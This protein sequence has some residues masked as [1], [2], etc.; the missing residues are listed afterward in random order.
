M[1]ETQQ[2]A[3][4]DQKRLGRYE[5]LGEIASGGMA[6][7]F[8]AR[9]LGHGGFQRLMAIKRLHPHLE[10]DE[11]FVRMF[12]DEAR[13]AARI[14]HPNVVATLDVEDED[15]LYIV[16]E[17]IEGVTLLQLTRA[18][19]KMGDRVP[20]PVAI[21]IALDT[22]AG[23]HAAHELRDENEAFL[24]LVHRDVSPQNILLG[25]DGSARLTDFGIAKATSRLAVTRDGQLKGKIS[26]MAPEQTRKS[27]LDRRADVFAMGVVVWELLAGRRLFSGDSDVEVLNQLLFEAVPRLRDQAPSLPSMLE[28]TV[29]R[30]LERDPNSRYPSAS[31]FA[32]A[33]ERATR[34]LGGPANHRIVAAFVNKLAGERIARE[35]GRI[36]SGLPFFDPNSTGNFKAIDT[37]ERMPTSRVRPNSNFPSPDRSQEPMTPMGR[38]FRSP[39]M[40][41]PTYSADSDPR[42]SSRPKAPHAAPLRVPTIPPV[43][44]LQDT[45][46]KA[47]LL[48]HSSA[49][50]AIIE[51]NDST[52]AQPSPPTVSS[53]EA[54]PSKLR[55]K[56]PAP[57]APQNAMSVPVSGASIDSEAVTRV[58]PSTRTPSY[59]NAV[60][61]SGMPVSML[62]GG[63]HSNQPSPLRVQ[64]PLF[65][66]EAPQPAMSSP[67]PS[68]QTSRPPDLIPPPLAFAQPQPELIATLPPPAQPSRSLAKN[69]L[70]ALGLLTA[71]AVG[72]LGA[73]YATGFFNHPNTGTPPRPYTPELADV[74]VLN[75]PSSAPDGM[76]V[77][78]EAA[79]DASVM[80]NI[81]DATL[82]D[83]STTQA[84]LADVIDTDVANSVLDATIDTTV[85]SLTTDDASTRRRRRRHEELTIS[86]PYDTPRPVPVG[87]LAKKS[88]LFS[89]D[90]NGEAISRCL[91]P[92]RRLLHEPALPCTDWQYHKP[93]SHDRRCV[94]VLRHV[95][96]IV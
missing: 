14:R 90:D 58:G 93:M 79:I 57:I 31:H 54:E 62:F 17:Y 8:L 13:L 96:V 61:P 52:E 47:T 37:P 77:S 59:G 27:E 30:A 38:S 39:T 92:S 23:L 36:A 78:D 63:P 84:V 25:T 46:R 2:D 64:T 51:F 95:Q 5:V 9:A 53:S 10:D 49:P 71:M 85:E 7:V 76:V 91:R 80:V 26:Y 68:A 94:Q 69:I 67:A 45:S 83:T 20:V 22:L 50:P 16:M 29:M 43:D 65:S 32:D 74:V 55:A 75:A 12:L 89:E 19:A 3:T 15:G 73:L 72:A 28:Q 6:T 1:T 21:R 34:M 88:T 24:N 56:T 60:P 4:N 82:E 44:A 42:P 66:G 41:G 70:F 11:D 86:N 35:R 40:T 81:V 48:G 87:P 18:A 33:L